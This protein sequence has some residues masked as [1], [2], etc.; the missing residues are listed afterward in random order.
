MILKY[1]MANLGPFSFCAKLW[2]NCSKFGQKVVKISP[3]Y[4]QISKILSH[5]WQAWKNWFFTFTTF[6]APAIFS[7]H[8]ILK[9]D[10]KMTVAKKVAKVKNQLFHA[11]QPCERIV[12]I[13]F[14]WGL[15]FELFFQDFEQLFP[16]FFWAFS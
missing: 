14:Y 7:I 13:Y 9:K 16:S 2:N 5:G 10:Q 3:Q 1:V 4:E 12:E 8:E 15:I 11:C 6:L